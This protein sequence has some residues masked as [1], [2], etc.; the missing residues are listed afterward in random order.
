MEWVLLA[1]AVGAGLYFYDTAS[2]VG[3]LLDEEAKRKALLRVQRAQE[4]LRHEVEAIEEREAQI[5]KQ[6]QIEP[7]NDDLERELDRL[8]MQKM[9]IT[10]KDL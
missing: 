10:A 5:W 1:I 7:G 3:D 9:Q 4:A 6:L 2:Q 8:H